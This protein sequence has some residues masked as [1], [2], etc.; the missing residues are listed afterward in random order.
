MRR[1]ITY[2]VVK[3]KNPRHLEDIP[4]F[5][6]QAQARGEADI[7]SLSKH[8]QVMC[9]MTPADVLGVLTALEM[10]VRY[11]LENGE[12]VR[13]GSLGSLQISLSCEGATTEEEFTPSLIRRSRIIFRPGSSLTEMQRVL[14]YEK[15]EQRSKLKDNLPADSS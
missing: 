2:S 13:L 7:N 14:N 9:S 8:I 3:R 5:Y 12:I 6:A 1:A 4:K 10:A 11:H 15:V